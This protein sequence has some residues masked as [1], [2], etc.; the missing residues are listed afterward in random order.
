[1]KNDL[2]IAKVHINFGRPTYIG[3]NVDMFLKINQKKLFRFR[4]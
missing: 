4:K 3:F 2:E 1:M